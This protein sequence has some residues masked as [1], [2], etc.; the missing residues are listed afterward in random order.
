MQSCQLIIGFTHIRQ[1]FTLTFWSLINLILIVSE[2]REETG[3]A[4]ENPQTEGEHA[5]LCSIRGTM[6][7]SAWSHIQTINTGN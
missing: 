6:D 3:A 2:T 4:G 5:Q 1:S 7:L